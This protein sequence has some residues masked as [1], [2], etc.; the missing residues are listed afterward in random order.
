MPLNRAYPSGSY[1]P[2][3]Y[4]PSIFLQEVSLSFPFNLS[5]TLTVIADCILFACKEGLIFI[6]SDSLVTSQVTFVE[7][8]LTF[9]NIF[10]TENGLMNE[11]SIF[12]FMLSLIFF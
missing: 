1:I 12:I 9:A 4:L 3:S 8:Y 6:S 2:Q 7:T 11:R 5:F 10:H